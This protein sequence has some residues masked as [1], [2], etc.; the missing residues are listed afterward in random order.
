MELEKERCVSQFLSRRERQCLELAAQ[1]K[2]DW[3]V[4]RI[5]GISERTVH[6]HIE[7]AKHRLGV[8]TRVQAI[9]QALFARHISFGDVM[10]GNPQWLDDEGRAHP[11]GGELEKL[12]ESALTTGYRG[13]QS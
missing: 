7:R 13:G 5:L 8:A 12:G 11:Q 3:A 1:G 4:G 2:S 10:A 9:V 6:H